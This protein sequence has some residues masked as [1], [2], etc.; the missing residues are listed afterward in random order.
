MENTLDALS[1]KSLAQDLIRANQQAEAAEQERLRRQ[2]EHYEQEL[3]VLRDQADRNMEAIAGLHDKLDSA[4]DK[5]HDTGVRI[6]RNVQAVILDEQKKQT[7]T[8]TAEF[9]RQFQMLYARM[10]AL[11]KNAEADRLERAEEREQDRQAT[12]AMLKQAVKKEEGETAEKEKTG[13]LSILMLAGLIAVLALNVLM[14][15]GISF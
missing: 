12:A 7:E 2:A 14:F 11:E 8:I 13:A 3:N 1:E 5:T 9:A 6:Y 10:D 4:N 15:L